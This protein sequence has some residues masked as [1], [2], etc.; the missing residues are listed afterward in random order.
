MP[1]CTRA[2]QRHHSDAQAACVPA[3]AVNGG[4]GLQLSPKP[5]HK[6]LCV[7][8][9]SPTTRARHSACRRRWRRCRVLGLPLDTVLLACALL[10]ATCAAGAIWR[11]RDACVLAACP[12]PVCR[13]REGSLPG[14]TGDPSLACVPHL[15]TPPCR[16]ACLPAPPPP[17]SL[18]LHL[19]R[20]LPGRTPGLRGGWPALPVHAAGDDLRGPHVGAAPL[21]A[22]LLALL[23]R[24]RH[25]GGE[26]LQAEGVCVAPGSLPA[27][28]PLACRHVP[29]A[30]R[31][32]PASRRWAQQGSQHPGSA[33]LH[34]QGPSCAPPRRSRLGA[35]LEQGHT[36]GAGAGL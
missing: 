7:S 6:G 28:R 25:P 14:P 19:R 15:T 4:K 27:R 30:R 12:R 11:R 17:C 33:S 31:D 36:A 23:L 5:L 2:L 1:S 35:G 10:V 22:P 34:A 16:P 21:R 29:V 18:R 3:S 13:P 20:A 26:W 32:P 9:M 24:Q 8:P